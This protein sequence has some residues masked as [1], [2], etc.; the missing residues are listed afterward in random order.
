MYYQ[1]PDDK[2]HSGMNDDDINTL[3]VEMKSVLCA[4]HDIT[5]LINTPCRC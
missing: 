4:V 5:R 1:F 3:D 2:Q